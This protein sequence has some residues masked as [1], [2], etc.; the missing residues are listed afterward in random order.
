MFVNSSNVKRGLQA[1]STDRETGRTTHRDDVLS[2]TGFEL[3]S[4][5]NQNENNL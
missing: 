2:L 1:L 5:T 4:Q 3:D